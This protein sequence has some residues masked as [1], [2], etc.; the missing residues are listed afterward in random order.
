MND[1]AR[2]EVCRRMTSRFEALS[3]SLTF[4]VFSSCCQCKCVCV[5]VCACMLCRF[6]V[7]AD[8]LDDCMKFNNLDLNGS[9]VAFVISCATLGRI[10]RAKD[11]AAGL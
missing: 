1:D 10:V 2:V 3:L 5:C 8:D 9:I 7:C 11:A 6:V 4:L